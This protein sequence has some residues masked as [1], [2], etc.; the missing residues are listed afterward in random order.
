MTDF[1]RRSFLGGVA[2]A[3][4]AAMPLVTLTRRAAAQSAA[5]PSST[6]SSGPVRYGSLVDLELCDGCPDRDTPRCVTACR[7]AN[8]H[9][10]PEPDPEKIRDY[11]PQKQHE[12][13]SNRRDVTDRLTPY[14]WTF[15]QSVDVEHDGETRRVNV[16]RRCMHCDN[17]PC[18]KLCP[19]GAAQKT[20]EGPVTINEGLCLGGAKCRIV[21]P[22][23]VPQRQ[24][25]VG[26]YTYLDPL[27]VGGGVM[28]KCDLC[29]DELAAGNTPAC[30]SGC[31]TGAIQIGDRDALF[32]DAERRAREYGGDRWRDHLYGRDE[33]GGTSTVYVSRVPFRA[34]DE[35]IVADGERKREALAARNPEAA[36]RMSPMRMHGTDNMLERHRG[37]AAASVV[38]PLMGAAAAF[39]ATVSRLETGGVAGAKR[40]RSTA[41][42]PASGE[43]GGEASGNASGTRLPVVNGKGGEHE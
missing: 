11:W 42:E 36:A 10:F 5:P 15:V 6:P 7:T 17:P 39:A 19:F 33:H 20:T 18:V 12:D 43:S 23:D 26:V 40:E 29:V 41:G 4:A 21:C 9:R 25:G 31:P 34:I 16:P 27:P 3:T 30:A 32:A 1:S 38:A 28:Y 37:L 2:A 35:A 8:A 24:A 14:N 22:W 13:W